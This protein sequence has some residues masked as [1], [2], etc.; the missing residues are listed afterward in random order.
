MI[1]KKSEIATIV[2]KLANLMTEV[3]RGSEANIGILG[4]LRES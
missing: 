2:G 3:M 4:P 1:D